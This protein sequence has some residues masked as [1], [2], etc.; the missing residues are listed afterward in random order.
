MRKSKSAVA[1]KPGTARPL[2]R[3]IELPAGAGGLLASFDYGPTAATL[4][5]LVVALLAFSNSM[6][7]E[8]IYDDTSQFPARLQRHNYSLF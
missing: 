2:P 5:V 1:A 3:I 7:G 6:G 4:I 8:L